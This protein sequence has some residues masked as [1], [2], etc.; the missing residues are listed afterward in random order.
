MLPSQTPDCCT[1]HIESRGIAFTAVIDYLGHCQLLQLLYQE[2][3]VCAFL[4][5]D[6]HVSQPVTCFLRPIDCAPTTV[7]P[8][9]HT[10]QTTIV[11]TLCVAA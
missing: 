6:K 3:E 7:S 9:K 1:R 4:H 10:K 2:E 8:F 11:A 5:I